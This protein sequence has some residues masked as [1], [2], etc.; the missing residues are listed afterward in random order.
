MIFQKVIHSTVA[1][2][3]TELQFLN[4]A[5]EMHS[6]IRDFKFNIAIVIYKYMNLRLTFKF[7][8]FLYLQY[9]NIKN[10]QSALKQQSNYNLNL[11]KQ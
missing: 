1:G 7:F 8:K 6:F 10:N 2:W 3:F 4:I 5:F 9:S 11:K